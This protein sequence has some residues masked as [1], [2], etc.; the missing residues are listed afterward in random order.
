MNSN[1]SSTTASS[2]TVRMQTLRVQRTLC[3]QVGGAL[4]STSADCVEGVDWHCSKLFTQTA[5]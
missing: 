5:T 2:K 1:D 3:R 4:P